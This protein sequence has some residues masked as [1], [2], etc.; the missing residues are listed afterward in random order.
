[1]P[2]APPPAAARGMPNVTCKIHAFLAATVFPLA[3]LALAGGGGDAGCVDFV[4]SEAD[5]LHNMVQLARSECP[6]LLASRAHFVARSAHAFDAF[7]GE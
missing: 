7:A 6:A 3:D 1:M 4:A 2:D 5:T